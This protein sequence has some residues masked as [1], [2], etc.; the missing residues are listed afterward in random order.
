MWPEAGDINSV[1]AHVCSNI[2]CW[3]VQRMTRREGHGGTFIEVPCPSVIAV[4][5]PH[6]FDGSMVRQGLSLYLH[7]AL[8]LTLIL[9]M[10]PIWRLEVQSSATNLTHC[11]QQQVRLQELLTC[12]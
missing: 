10:Q 11:K 7:L 4:A 2:A 9:T 1:G 3:R 5:L 12:V 6:V 8:S